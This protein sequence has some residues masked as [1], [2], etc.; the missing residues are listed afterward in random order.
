MAPTKCLTNYPTSIKE[1]K[2]THSRPVMV[3]IH[4]GS[5]YE[6]SGNDDF[7]GPD[8][9]IEEDVILVSEPFLYSEKCLSKHCTL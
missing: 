4:G 6:G 5:F 8:F 1:V 3:Y 7:L 9:L 2:P